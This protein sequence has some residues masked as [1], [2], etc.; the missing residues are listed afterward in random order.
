MGIKSGRGKILAHG[1]ATL[2][3]FCLST[4]VFA[5]D[6]LKLAIGQKGAFENAVA[7]LGG[8]VGIFKKHGIE[9]EIVYTQGSGET[10]QAVISG[11]ADIGVSAGTLGVMSV[12]AKGAPVRI[13]GAT[14]HGAND[15]FW[16]VRP[17]SPIKTFRDM[18]GKTVS[19]STRGSSTNTAVLAFKDFFKIAFKETPVGGPASSFTQMMSGQVDVG[20]SGGTILLD[21]VFDGTVR[22]IGRASEVPDLQ[23]VTPRVLIV[24]LNTL[25]KRRDVMLRFMAAY[26]ETR[27]WL[28]SDPKA[29]EAYAKWG[30]FKLEVAQKAFE[31]TY[32]K[33]DLDP[34]VIRGIDLLQ[35][36]AVQFK[37]IPKELSAEQL[38]DLL[39][40]P[41][42]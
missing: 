21:K 5:A 32:P 39:R 30:E 25:E 36:D 17:D 18:A 42:K 14:M 27:E 13:F 11:S 4:G 38:A 24:N 19:Y 37:Y 35:R 2:L 15:L 41:F 22:L 1:V 26:R 10:V 20:W 31:T 8:E 6:Q 23:N 40:V 28:Y 9:L 34:D 7:P 16:Y 3:V 33:A 29:L 12:F